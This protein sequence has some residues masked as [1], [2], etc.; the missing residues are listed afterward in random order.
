MGDTGKSGRPGLCGSGCRGQGTCCRPSGEVQPGG[1]A[2]LCV[3]DSRTAAESDAAAGTTGCQVIETP[4]R[5]AVSRAAR[6]AA[7]LPAARCQGRWYASILVSE[8][9]DAGLPAGAG[10]G[11]PAYR[12]SRSMM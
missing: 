1:A 7:G 3:A 5:Q 9:V 4:G 10:C 2:D 6:H 8:A 12:P 11:V